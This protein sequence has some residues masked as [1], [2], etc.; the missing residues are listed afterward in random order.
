MD[1]R[2]KEGG[3]VEVTPGGAGS[4]R[5]PRRHTHGQL[6]AGGTRCWAGSTCGWARRRARTANGMPTT[7][8]TC[9]GTPMVATTCT[10]SS[11][12]QL[13]SGFHTDR[14][15]PAREAWSLGQP[16]QGTGKEGL[17]S[18]S[19]G[20]MRGM[21]RAGVVVA[22]LLCSRRLCWPMRPLRSPAPMPGPGPSTPW[23]SSTSMRWI[24][25][26]A[27]PAVQGWQYRHC[28]GSTV[29]LGT[30]T[31][32]LAGWLAGRHRR[33]SPLRSMTQHTKKT[34]HTMRTAHPSGPDS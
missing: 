29:A 23:Q 5:L 30:T 33:T 24:T 8:C 28:R 16:E 34:S 21:R 7:Y 14:M 1:R 13:A 15:T 12:A 26:L 3:K 22:P 20:G 2:W 6:R 9:V 31:G 10:M 27:E 17:G 19:G 32:W 4:G 11:R 25:N 18:I